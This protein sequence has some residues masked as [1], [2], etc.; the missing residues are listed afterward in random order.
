MNAISALIK[1]TPGSTLLMPREDTVSEPGSELSPDPESARCFELG[2]GFASQ[3][4]E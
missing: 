3:S 2:S 4:P 1:E